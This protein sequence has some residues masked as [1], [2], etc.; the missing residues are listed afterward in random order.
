MH[1][2]I[3]SL[4]SVRLTRPRGHVWIVGAAAIL[5]ALA[6]PRI[7]DAQAGTARPAPATVQT[8]AGARPSGIGVRGFA[9]VDLQRMTAGQTFEAVLGTRNL[10][11]FGGGADVLRLWRN[12]FARV[13]VSR[14]S[15]EGTRVIVV[16]DEAIPVG[17]ATSIRMMPLEIAGGWQV[18][19][20]RFVPYVGGGLLRL[21]YEETTD[22]D[23]PGDETST[24]FNG[25][26]L[27]GGVNLWLGGPLGVGAEVQHRHLIGAIGQ[28]GASAAFGENDLGGV[29]LRVWIGIGR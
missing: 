22:F 27:F 5:T 3:D 10:P 4:A 9:I 6:M 24:T 28:A 18:G 12:A 2:L 26:V 29:T 19:R 14:T 21:R 16:G 8:K 25:S 11:G 1:T 7:A 23:L 15:Q 20:G 17:I 13:A